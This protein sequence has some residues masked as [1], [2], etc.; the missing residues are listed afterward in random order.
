ME[1]DHCYWI[2]NTA[3]IAVRMG[4]HRSTTASKFDPHSRKIYR[5]I[6][7]VVPSRNTLLTLHGLDAVRRFQ[8]GEFHTPALTKDNWGEEI[9]S[10]DIEDL[11]PPIPELHKLFLV[12]SCKV[13]FLGSNLH[14]STRLKADNE[15]RLADSGRISFR[16]ILVLLY[17]N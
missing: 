17:E 14:P 16:P 15:R 7:W 3:R 6:W 2:S 5:R 12:E 8:H 11:L 4:L 9:I 13:Q 10:P 1:K